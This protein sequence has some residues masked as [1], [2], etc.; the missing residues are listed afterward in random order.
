MMN[1][2]LIPCLDVVYIGT[3]HPY[4][5]STG[6]LFMKSK[7][8]VLIEKPL[9]MNLREVQELIAAARDNS[10]F[11]MEV[12]CNTNSAIL[13]QITIHLSKPSR[14]FCPGNLDTFLPCIPGS[15]ETAG[16]R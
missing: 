11:L 6:K 8:N 13:T 7:K 9:A 1:S 2:S 3:I 14:V 10:V 15:E 5:L 4:H 12:T 16:P